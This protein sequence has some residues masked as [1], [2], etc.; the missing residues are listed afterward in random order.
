MC[1]TRG[2][3]PGVS[4]RV[5]VRMINCERLIAE[6]YKR[7]PLWNS[8]NVLH[9]SA[10]ATSNLWGEV[11]EI[12]G[13]DSHSVKKKWKGLRDYYR[14]ELKKMYGHKPGDTTINLNI[15]SHQVS[16][17]PYYDMLHFL[18]DSMLSYYIKPKTKEPIAVYPDD[19]YPQDLTD[20]S[21][22]PANSEPDPVVKLL[23]PREQQIA[24]VPEPDSPELPEHGCQ[25]EVSLLPVS[26]L[27]TLAEIANVADPAGR[28]KRPRLERTYSSQMLEIERQRSAV[29][30]ERRSV[31]LERRSVEKEICEPDDDDFLFLRSLLPD[32]KILP[33]S[34]KLLV[35]IKMQEMVYN[36]I[37]KLE[38]ELSEN[39]PFRV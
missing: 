15:S 27:H 29:E 33:R 39:R 21:S 16:T 31:E 23:T 17:W 18:K 14:T 11:A 35:R 8:Y 4:R 37:S 9:R 1:D 12:L 25:T 10:V 38:S 24:E 13:S 5:L 3:Y 26:G 28:R 20:R 6:V 36:E 2:R 32:I 7:E 30:V 19:E 22:S 34:R